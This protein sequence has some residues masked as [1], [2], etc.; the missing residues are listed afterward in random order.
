MSNLTAASSPLHTTIHRVGRKITMVLPA[1]LYFTL[2]VLLIIL[3]NLAL[4][5]YNILALHTAAQGMIKQKQHVALALG[6]I[7]AI[8]LRVGLTLIMCDLLVFSYAK[9]IAGFL[10]LW[11]CRD[12]LNTLTTPHCFKEAR[13]SHCLS[14]TILKIII[15][16]IALSLDSNIATASIAFQ[17]HALM[18]TG[19][20][21]S[22]FAITF[23]ACFAPTFFLKQRWLTWFG[24]AILLALALH[25]LIRGGLDAWTSL[26]L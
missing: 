10:L 14:E 16:D 12:C 21:V 1:P 26:S 23:F 6:A 4:S 11:A 25:L 9:I 15:T 7:L 20:I 5:S 8:L 19:L 3:L 2:L 18:A 24:L 22:I 13:S 17:H